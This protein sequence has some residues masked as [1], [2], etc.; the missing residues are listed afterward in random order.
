M[1]ILV[2]LVLSIQSCFVYRSGVLSRADSRWNKRFIKRG[3]D[4]KI[5]SHFLFVEKEFTKILLFSES[6]RRPN[7]PGEIYT[8][9]TNMPLQRPR[10]V[11]LRSGMCWSTMYF[12]SYI[13]SY[14]TWQLLTSILKRIKDPSMKTICEK[15]AWYSLNLSNPLPRLMLIYKCAYMK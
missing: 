12:Q 3:K 8:S 11:G 1:F 10:L 9:E 14:T 7:N 13:F 15:L 4:G 5:F 6:C 2:F